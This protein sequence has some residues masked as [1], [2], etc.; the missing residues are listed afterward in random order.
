[1]SPNLDTDP[2]PGVYLLAV[3]SYLVIRTDRRAVSCQYVDNPQQYMCRASQSIPPPHPLPLEDPGTA[4]S[5]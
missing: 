1:M 2:K 5:W 3:D 4:V